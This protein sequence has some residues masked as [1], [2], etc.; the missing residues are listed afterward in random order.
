MTDDT[1]IVDFKSK[2]KKEEE[3]K[4]EKSE[5]K[6]IEERV[7]KCAITEDCSCA[8]CLYKKGAIEMVMEFL[9]MDIMQFERNNKGTSFCSYDL[10][11]ILF[12]TILKIKEMEKEQS[13]ES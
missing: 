6:A 1:N 12:E 9:A 8:H 3:P 7:L 5:Y 10:K 13:S 2:K 4:N 11:D